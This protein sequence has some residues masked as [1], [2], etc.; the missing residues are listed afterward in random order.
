MGVT[1][2]GGR[3]I[4][5]FIVEDNELFLQGL[6]FFLESIEGVEVAGYSLDGKGLVNA[7]E[8]SR[9]DLVIMDLFLPK[10]SGVTLTRMLCRRFKN[11][12]VIVLSICDE[13]ECRSNAQRAG[14]SA[15]IT[16]GQS[17][18]KLKSSILELAAAS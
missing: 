11:L 1:H 7:I 2:S 3:P 17:L 15:Y 10:S 12:K 16:K 9:P 6:I 13:E 8:R 18:E 14:A 5:I 4:R